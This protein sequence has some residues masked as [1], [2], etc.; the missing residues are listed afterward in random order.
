MVNLNQLMLYN[1][2][3]MRIAI[4]FIVVSFFWSCKSD[5]VPTVVPK[6]EIKVP[7]FDSN[8]AFAKVQKQLEFGPRV[9]G[10]ATHDDCKDW[11]AQTMSEYGWE[12]EEQDFMAD[13]YTGESLPGTNVIAKLNPNAQPRI[14][15]A[16]HYDTRH[17]AEK[18]SD[19]SRY[20]DPIPGAD[21]GASGVAV[22]MSLAKIISEH[23][24]EIGIDIV[25]FDAEDYGNPDEDDPDSWAIGSVHWAKN[26]SKNYKPK[27]AILL[28]MVGSKNARFGFEQYS[29]AVA[30]T[31]VNKIWKLAQDMGYGNYFVS[32]NSGGVHDDH[33][34]VINHA[35][36]P[37]INIINKTPQG[38]FGAYHHTHQ[39]DISIIDR[40]TMK[41]VGQVMLAVIYNTQNGKF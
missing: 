13:L 4:I 15:L 25:F 18:D 21:D 8:L 10:T 2:T 36:I 7:R 1:R 24:I 27:H 12:V 29:M 39:D 31:L 23:P 30:P 16:A 6:T 22:L 26:V 19:K 35:G 9:I 28:D 38:T 5:P 33:I 20:N 34:S 40:R 3:E 14:L 32:E 11:I 41:A 17:I 37:M